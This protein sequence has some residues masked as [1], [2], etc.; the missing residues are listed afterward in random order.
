MLWHWESEKEIDIQNKTIALCSI[1]DGYQPALSFNTRQITDSISFEVSTVNNF[2]VIGY[3]INIA[4]EGNLG[5]A[6]SLPI[7]KWLRIY[8]SWPVT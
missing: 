2:L 1:P 4:N 6:A 7:N 5:K 8:A 3:G